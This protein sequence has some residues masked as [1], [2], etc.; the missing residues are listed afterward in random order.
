M[1]YSM[2]GYG[3]S[4]QRVDGVN[5]IVEIK[6]VNNRYFKSKIQLPESIAF[7]EEA[8]EN[9]LRR[10]LERGMVNF[11]AYIKDAPAALL[12]DIDEGVLGELLKKVERIAKTT[13]AKHTIDVA[14]L[15]NLPDVIS[16]AKLDSESSEKIKTAI[17]Q[18]TEK[19]IVQLRQMRAAEGQSLADDLRRHCEQIRSKLTLIRQRSET[20]LKDYA[21]RLQKRAQE[22]LGESRLGIDELSVAKEVAIFAERSDI[23]EEIDRLDS[24]IKQFTD[25]LDSDASAD[26]GKA[27][28]AGRRLDFI[29]QEMLREANTI[30]SKAADSQIIHTVV[31]IKCIIDR[32]KE[33]VQNVE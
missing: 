27:A 29:C 19:A 26:T 10:R 5:Y 1:I 24:H 18:L 33:Q 12:F 11:V 23:S 22:L 6:T 30:A 21:Q 15:L 7:L 14:S 25:A 13:G 9:L 17:L 32:I 4:E 28:Q 3:S 31:D 16:P 2:T 8:V 20:V